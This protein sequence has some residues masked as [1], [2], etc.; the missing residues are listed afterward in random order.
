M[1]SFPEPTGIMS[2]ARYFGPAE[3]TGTNETSGLFRVSF[4]HPGSESGVITPWARLALPLS[5]GL[6]DGDRVLVAGNEN[7]FYIIGVLGDLSSVRPPENRLELSCGV[8]A[9]RTG[10]PGAETL[11]VLTGQ[12][13]VLF[14]YD[15]RI[16]KSRVS[17]PS[18]DLEFHAENGEIVLSSSKGI[19]LTAPGGEGKGGAGLTL[20]P[21]SL[22]LTGARVGITSEEG[23][24]RIGN[25]RYM[26]D[27]FSGKVKSVGI[28]MNR[29]ET[30]A[31]TVVQKA[32]N[33]YQTVEE[34][35]QMHAGRMRALIEST[36]HV[37]TR[38]TFLKS[39]GDVKINGDKIYLG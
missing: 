28:V 13:G 1:S 2:A 24:F 8:A 39:D 34:L 6:H 10:A 26:G 11:R 19:R 15:S 17:A 31:E 22:H 36:W 25:T 37:K 21:D 12:G 7:E 20:A 16:G 38:R 29:L 27:A 32:K 30:T 3:V 4:P 5:H 9:E 35:A 14:E 23:D 18:G 33:I